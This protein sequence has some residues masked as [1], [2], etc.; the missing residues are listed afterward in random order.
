MKTFKK[1]LA[2]ALVFTS[3]A[4]NAQT[5][6][7]IVAK[8]TTAMGG[9]DKIKTLVSAKKS[10]NISTTQGDFPMT[11]TIMQGK[12][13]RLDMEIMGT[14]NY[15]IATPEKGSRFFPIQGNTEPI[16]FDADILESSQNSFDL[17]GALFD[18]K[19][20]GNTIELVGKE[21]V[22][23]AEAY[24]LKVTRKSGKMSFVFVDVKTN[25]VIKTFSK[26]K[27]PDGAEKE[28]T[29]GYSDYKQNKDGFWFAY[30][31]ESPNGKIVFD[32]IETNIKVDENIYKN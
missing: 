29:N 22:D 5:V 8:N 21:K 27:G 7:E 31:N 20:K 9:A 25:F 19:T 14:S 30:A 15:Q 13:F 24:K 6:D 23:N 11:F 2:A 26:E 28:I 18:Y 12:G 32:T 10:A 1:L 4:A 16:E 17:Q 3:F